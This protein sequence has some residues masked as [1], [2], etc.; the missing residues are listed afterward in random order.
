M[1]SIDRCREILGDEASDLTDEEV[2]EVRDSL[3]GFAHLACDMAE[4][5]DADAASLPETT[6]NDTIPL[7]TNGTN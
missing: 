4:S 3:Y 2:R 1:L 6:E 5:H 7:F